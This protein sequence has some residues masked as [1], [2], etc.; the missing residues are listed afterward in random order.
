MQ[1]WIEQRTRLAS[2]VVTDAEVI[3]DKL[4]AKPLD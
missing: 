2:P 4:R 1:Q 3:D